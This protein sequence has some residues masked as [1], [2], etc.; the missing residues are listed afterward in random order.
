MSGVSN[1]FSRF[2]IS[3]TPEGKID[4]NTR[5]FFSK[6][7]GRTGPAIPNVAITG[8]D[9]TD[10]TNIAGTLNAIIAEFAAQGW[11]QK[12]YDATETAYVNSIRAVTMIP[13]ATE[14]G[15]WPKEALRD[16]IVTGAE[17]IET[18]NAYSQYDP[19]QWLLLYQDAQKAGR[20]GGAKSDFRQSLDTLQN[21]APNVERVNLFVSWYGTDLRAGSC[22]LVPGVTRNDFDNVP[23]EWKCAGYTRAT[24]HLVSIWNGGAAYGGTPDDQSIADCIAELNSRGLKVAF[25]PF[26]LMDIPAG[27]ALADPYTGQTGQPV[28][29]WRG[30]ITKQ[31]ATA[32][33]TAGVATEVAAFVAQY[34]NFVLHYAN[35]CAGAGGVE[36][37][38]LG[39][40]LRGLTWLRDAPGSYPFVTALKAL[41]A[42]VAAIL[43]MAKLTYAA[44]WS[45]YFGHQP[46]DGSGDVYF[47]LDSLWAD[48]NIAAIGIDNYWPT[49]DWR[50]SGPNADGA[51]YSE[52]YDYTY[53]MGNM[54]G[55]EGYSWYYAS[56]ADRTNQVRTA[57]TDGAY[58]KP[59][60]FRY[61]DIWNWW[62]NLH[63]NRPGGIEQSVPT[64]WMPQSKPVWFT[65]LGAPSIDKGTNE[66]NVFYD[67]KSSESAVPYFSTGA[68]DYLIQRRGVHAKLRYFDSNDGTFV[69]S[70]N[71]PS[72]VYSGLMADLDHAY[73]YTWDARPFPAFPLF[74]QVWG[75]YGNWVYGHWISGKLTSAI[76]QGTPDTMAVASTL[77]PRH[78]YIVD[79]A[80]GK[81]DKQYR[82]FFQGIE[83]V[84]GDPIQNVPLEPTPQECANAINALLAVMVQQNRLIS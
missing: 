4:N 10:W 58:N 45:E 54:Q 63:Y 71:P 83:F 24:A 77:A 59:W 34:R 60:V 57:I 26:V 36:V 5:A 13:A 78:P 46:Q 64:E 25:T 53:L 1:L 28:Y 68:S 62:G 2:G 79:P 32:D 15:Y 51:A 47:H 40:E 66:P 30:R 84:Q 61:K 44:D 55:G 81:L 31:Y 16:V 41:A 14:W 6:Y 8:N 27:N 33:E 29:P 42:D 35:L 80:T 7:N 43:P 18:E 9:A 76:Q 82:D 11:M 38:I 65:E 67:P 19:S 74:S 69:S 20:I 49:S 52:I 39:T 23:H 37:F 12:G 3:I 22:Q 48:T 50:D 73:V 70:R 17:F 21:T 75:D 56:D 72:Q